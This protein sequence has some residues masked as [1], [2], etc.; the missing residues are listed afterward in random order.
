MEF[1]NFTFDIDIPVIQGRKILAHVVDVFFKRILV[2]VDNG[3]F[4][5]GVLYKFRYPQFDL[6]DEIEVSLDYFMIENNTHQLITTPDLKLML[7]KR[8]SAG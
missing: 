7:I 6:L 2:L 3:R 1:D 8:E 5:Q 4:N